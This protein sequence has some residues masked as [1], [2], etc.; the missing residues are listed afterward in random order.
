MAHG[1]LVPVVW[2]IGAHATAT[3]AESVQLAW[4]STVTAAGSRMWG[5]ST[6]LALSVD[7]VRV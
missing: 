2:A 6:P 7:R 3:P 1:R 4:A 5:D